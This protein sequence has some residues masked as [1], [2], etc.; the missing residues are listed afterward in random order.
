MLVTLRDIIQHPDVS[1]LSLMWREGA[2]P[3][4][5]GGSSLDS[6][7]RLDNEQLQ[8]ISIPTARAAAAAASAAGGGGGGAG[9][10]GGGGFSLAS[11]SAG[12]S[13]SVGGAASPPP[14]QAR[15]V[16]AMSVSAVV[17]T[18]PP[19]A[20]AAASAAAAAE[21]RTAAGWTSARN[22]IDS[23]LALLYLLDVSAFRALVLRHQHHLGQAAQA[24]AAAALPPHQPSLGTMA[25]G[26]GGGSGG[27]GIGS[28][29][30]GG[31]GRPRRMKSLHGLG[32]FV[33]R[34]VTGSRGGKQHHHHHHHDAGGGGDGGG[35][36]G[37]G[38]G[39][40]SKRRSST[41]GFGELS[42]EKMA[43]LRQK[44]P[45][46]PG[47]N[48]GGSQ[49]SGSTA[50]SGPSPRRLLH[51]AE[52]WDSPRSS[53]DDKVRFLLVLYFSP[54]LQGI[55]F[56]RIFSPRLQGM[57]FS[58]IF[59]PSSSRYD[60][61]PLLL[62]LLMPAPLLSLLPSFVVFSD[63][64][65]PAVSFWPFLFLCFIAVQNRR[66]SFCWLDEAEGLLVEP[67]DRGSG[68]VCVR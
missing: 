43:A 30:G 61:F 13:R 15:M 26:S 59:F 54:R 47:S 27:G 17:E 56:T 6:S 39:H 53:W 46:G 57:I 2:G 10:A 48:F 7:G 12:S 22:G 49:A 1:A 33:S 44:A 24:A 21:A 45:P 63:R 66:Q 60:S 42:A 9:G 55:I 37:G 32:S 19:E 35:D 28:G 50:I 38:G 31:E 11:A 8:P 3:L 58:P 14:P 25:G 65:H 40:G 68:C 62:F 34:K 16:K 20:S 29:G 23:E 51:R 52:S 67:W 41:G 5:D 64:A 36:G 4:V 18:P